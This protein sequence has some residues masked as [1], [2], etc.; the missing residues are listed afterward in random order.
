MNDCLFICE[1]VRAVLIV[2]CPER[3]QGK[4][5]STY[6]KVNRPLKGCMW[7][8]LQ[9]V[10]VSGLGKSHPVS[11]PC[12]L[13]HLDRGWSQETARSLGIAPCIALLLVFSRAVFVLLKLTD[14]RLLQN[15]R[16]WD[17]GTLCWGVG[18]SLQRPG[19]GGEDETYE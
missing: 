4:K 14:K 12:V 19:L 5:T 7:L 15:C 2:R 3:G 8:V 16:K 6:M 9:T 13:L 10:P 17:S 1:F 11:Q 18:R